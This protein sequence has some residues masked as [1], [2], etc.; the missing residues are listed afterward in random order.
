METVILQTIKQIIEKPMT[1]T[2]FNFS[3]LAIFF[4]MGTSAGGGV[5]PLGRSEATT[6]KRTYAI[7]GPL[8]AGLR[9]VLCSYGLVFAAFAAVEILILSKS[10]RSV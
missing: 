4:V 7:G 1:Q 5:A 6:K 9:N 2:C 10:I 3:T 8:S